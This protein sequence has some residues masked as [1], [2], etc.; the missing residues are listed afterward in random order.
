MAVKTFCNHSLFA[1]YYYISE[2]EYMSKGC[3]IR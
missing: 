3:E 1:L 2:I